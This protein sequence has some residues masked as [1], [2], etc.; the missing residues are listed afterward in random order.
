[1]SPPARVLVVANRTADS[2]EVQAALL[3]RAQQSAI[4]VTVLAPA[5]WEVVDPHGGVQ[6][7]R[8]RL[9]DALSRLHGAGISASGV[10]G[11]A[12]PFVAVREIWDPER[13]DEVVVATLPQH[14]SRWL[15]LDLPRRVE[16]L[17]GRPVR[18][19]I[20][21]ERTPVGRSI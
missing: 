11:D 2:E 14:L 3:E 10:V 15:H 4:E 21:S 6:S 7:A 16:H 5:S 18:H 13:F 1:M 19:V 8:R 20:A 9:R 12:D 17:T